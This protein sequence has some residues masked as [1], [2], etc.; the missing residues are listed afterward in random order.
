MTEITF[1]RMIDNAE[2]GQN[3]SADSLV[4]YL[5]ESTE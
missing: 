5:K 3:G 1:G 4:R 2:R